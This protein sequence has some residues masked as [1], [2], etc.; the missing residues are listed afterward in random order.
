MLII[1]NSHQYHHSVPIHDPQVFRHTTD[2]DQSGPQDNSE[3]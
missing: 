3:Y 2:S 1:P